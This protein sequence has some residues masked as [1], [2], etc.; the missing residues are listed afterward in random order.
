MDMTNGQEHLTLLLATVLKKK[1]KKKSKKGRNRVFKSHT[2]VGR[3][4][5]VERS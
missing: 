1:K 3:R 2:G 5:E 4:A